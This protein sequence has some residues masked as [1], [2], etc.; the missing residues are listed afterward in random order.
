MTMCSC[1]ELGRFE[2]AVMSWLGVERPLCR[3]KLGRN[4]DAAVAVRYI[5]LRTG[6]EVVRWPK[7]S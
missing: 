6:V 7:W 3:N 2:L 4:V 1:R 5:F